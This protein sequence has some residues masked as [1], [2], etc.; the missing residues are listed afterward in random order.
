MKRI[1][2]ALCI[3]ITL[4]AVG[5]FASQYPSSPSQG[6]AQP[7]QPQSQ[8][9]M[10]PDQSAP[11]SAQPSQPQSAQPGEQAPQQQAGR[12]S[13]DDQVRMLTQ[14]LNLTPEQQGKMKT[15][16]EDQHQQA[17]TIINDSSIAREDKI[18]KIRSLRETTI[19]KARSMLNN[20]QKKKLDAMLQESDRMR[21][22]QGQGTSPSS[23]PSGTSP[24]SQPSSGSPGTA[25]PGSTPPMNNRPPR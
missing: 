18:Q 22:Q 11:G 8:G 4:L 10:H 23:G 15:V 21:Q 13:I 19:T 20:D 2:T 25:T 17:M 14:E 1:K 7:S 16:L 5:A 3:C 12:P 24:S 6:T 9:S